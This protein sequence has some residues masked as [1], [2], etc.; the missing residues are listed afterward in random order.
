MSQTKREKC[1]KNQ[2]KSFDFA[3]TIGVEAATGPGKAKAK[4]MKK[5]KNF[6]VFLR[7]T[8]AE[9]ADE[10]NEAGGGIY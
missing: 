2:R 10:P 9:G 1:W 7:N 4:S 3:Q 8:R 6:V 5:Q